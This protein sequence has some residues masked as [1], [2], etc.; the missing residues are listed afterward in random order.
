MNKNDYIKKCVVNPNMLYDYS[1][2]VSFKQV[3]AFSR[4]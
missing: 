1:P 4:E 2:A 3:G